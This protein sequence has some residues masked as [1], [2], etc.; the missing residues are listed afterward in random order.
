MAGRVA[1]PIRPRAR[2]GG[3]PPA[4]G[5]AVTAPRRGTS[6]ATSAPASAAAVNAPF[7]PAKALS[8]AAGLKT[9]ASAAG[10]ASPAL[11]R[12]TPRK[13][14]VAA[15]QAAIGLGIHRVLSSGGQARALDGADDLSA[16]VDAAE[17]LVEIVHT[18]KQVVCV[19]G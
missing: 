13:A 4:S 10:G 16:M 15:V 2:P 8:T 18:L 11:R 14:R 17:D 9:T 5:A 7:W 12:T 1:T 3:T 19:K 6:S